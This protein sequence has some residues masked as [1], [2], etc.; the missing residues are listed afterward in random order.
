MAESQSSRM[1]EEVAERESDCYRELRLVVE[2]DRGSRRGWDGEYG[3]REPGACCAPCR[4]LVALDMGA[5]A[6]SADPVRGRW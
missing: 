3:G 5:I 1:P 2:D 6:A 4:A